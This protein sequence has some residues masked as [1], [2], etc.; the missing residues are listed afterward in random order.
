MFRVLKIGQREVCGPGACEAIIPCKKDSVM[1][2]VQRSIDHGRNRR[3]EKDAMQQLFVNRF[4][5]PQVG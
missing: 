1:G 5:Q 3:L 4:L 2:H